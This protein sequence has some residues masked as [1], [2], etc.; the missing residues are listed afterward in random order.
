[1][2]ANITPL[3]LTFN[4]A[5]NIARTLECLAWAQDIVV[6]DSHSTDG[7]LEILAEHPR[8]RVFSRVFTTHA[9]QWNFGLEQTSIGAEWILA[10]DA[11]YVLSEALIFEI[12][13]LEDRADTGGYQA[14]FTYCVSSI[15][16]AFTKLLKFL[17]LF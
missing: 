2:I 1:M 9:E 10:L 4:E 16:K 11:D 13:C 17:A 14:G 6:V 3:I 7:T 15:L 8:V 5:A 12:R